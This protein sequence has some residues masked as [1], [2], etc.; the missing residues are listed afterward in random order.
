VVKGGS[1]TD[2]RTNL[3]CGILVTNTVA[4]GTAG[5]STNN[6]IFNLATGVPDI[7]DYR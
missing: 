1:I 4:L 3:K 5:F 7:I 2:P 6:L